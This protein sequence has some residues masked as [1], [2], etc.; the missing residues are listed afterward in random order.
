MRFRPWFAVSVVL[1]SGIGMVRA[2]NAVPLA[3]RLV[4]A[5]PDVRAQATREFN[6]LPPEA[7]EKFAPDLMVA[8]NDDDPAIRAQAAALLQGMNIAV[9]GGSADW[10]KAI[11]DE[12]RND[13]WAS[14][15]AAQMHDLQNA[16]QEAFPDLKR[17][18]DAEKKGVIDANSPEMKPSAQDSAP[19]AILEAL[20]DP[21]PWV[22]AHAVRKLG[23]LPHPPPEAIPLLIKMLKDKS[24]ELRASSAGALGEYGPAAH[25]AIPALLQTLGDGDPGVR[26]IT[27]EALKLIQNQN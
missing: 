24:P 12:K 21:D 22:R 6:Q 7:R 18:L 5:D 19:S 13:A 2:A 16:K 20:N 10:Q 3:R 8:V 15:H 9:P 23:L 11:D 27:G 26:Q 25:S 17:E 4:S 14:S 1:C